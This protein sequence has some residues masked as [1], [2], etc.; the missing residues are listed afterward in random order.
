[1]HF[2]T[3]GANDSK[4]LLI[5]PKLD[6]HADIQLLKVR[7]EQKS[8]SFTVGHGQTIRPQIPLSFPS[9]KRKEM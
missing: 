5:I 4:S 7:N 3:Q 9:K 1:V 8:L 6:L 2:D